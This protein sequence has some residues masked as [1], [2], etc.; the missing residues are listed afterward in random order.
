MVKRI[1]KTVTLSRLLENLSIVYVSLDIC[2]RRKPDSNTVNFVG[3]CCSNV[4]F[5]LRLLEL[6]HHIYDSLQY[7]PVTNGILSVIAEFEVKSYGAK[8]NRISDLIFRM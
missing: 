5:L 8:I 6:T 4:I 3:Y 7:S 2:N 1:R